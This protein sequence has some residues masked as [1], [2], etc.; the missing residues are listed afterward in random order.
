LKKEALFLNIISKT[1]DESEFLGDDC[2]YLPEYNLVISTDALIEDVH[3]SLNTISPYGL[4]KKALLVNVSDILA[5]GAVPK[6]STITLSGNLNEKF[7]K[8]FYKGV[9]EIC[10]KFD[11]KIIGGDLTGGEKIGISVTVLGDTKNRSISSRKNAKPGYTVLLAGYHGSSA[12]GLKI[13]NDIKEQLPS[14]QLLQ[15]KLPAENFFT[16]EAEEYFIKSHL[17][18][19]L[20]PKISEIVSKNC[21]NYAMMDTSDGLYDGLKK[22]SEASNTGFKIKYDRILKKIDDFNAVMFGGEDYGLLICLKDDDYKKVY[23]LLEHEDITVIG[24]V[25]DDKKIIVDDKEIT[26][27]LSYEHF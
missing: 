10:K 22:I 5:S 12:T 8:E 3:F 7:I 16:K 27:D 24:K 20:Y 25:T 18:P 13:L 2:A 11:L 23:P 14:K 21:K 1:L 9:N 4:G 6:Y 26:E 17:E 15:K 19:V